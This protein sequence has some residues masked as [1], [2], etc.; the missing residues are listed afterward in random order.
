MSLIGL[1]MN[2]VLAGLL[3]A[4]LSMGVRLNRRLKAL[5]DSQD[6]FATA[7]AELNAAA[8]RAEQ[9]L[10]DLRAATDEATDEL[11]DRIEKGR[12]LA[13]RLERL[14]AS[15]PDRVRDAPEEGDLGRDAERRL[16]AL[17]AA[18]REARTK[19]ERL[20]REQPK[21]APRPA[22]RSPHDPDADLFEDEPLTLDAPF[23]GRR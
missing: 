21:V 15:A 17:L 22:P 23:G 9:G 6:G 20:V 7:V 18:A 14:M 16:G 12:A 2:L 8:S 19:P 13:A 3:L 5:R 4:A 11:A 1:I 10:A